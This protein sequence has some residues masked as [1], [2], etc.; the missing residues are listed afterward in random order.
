MDFLQIL[1]SYFKVVSL[2]FSDRISAE[3][4]LHS[5]GR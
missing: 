3:K 1:T 4:A 2:I 5:Q